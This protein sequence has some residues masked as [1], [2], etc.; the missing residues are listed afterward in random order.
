MESL[1]PAARELDVGERGAAQHDTHGERETAHMQ[2]MY[3][4]ARYLA[5]G[6]GRSWNFTTALRVPRPPSICHTALGP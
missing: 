5:N 3:R 1:S 4:H 2:A 6:S